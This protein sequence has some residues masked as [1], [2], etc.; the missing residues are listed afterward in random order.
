MPVSMM[1]PAKVNRST[2]AAQSRGSVEVVVQ[3]ER[4][5]AGDR[6]AGGFL[7]LGESRMHKG[8]RRCSSFP[9]VVRLPV[10]S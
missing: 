8:I 5:I 10:L 7:P 2:I 1:L 3:P 6:H 4:L 9:E